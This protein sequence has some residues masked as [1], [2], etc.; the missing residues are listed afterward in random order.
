M[1][2]I[3]DANYGGKNKS[4][5]IFGLNEKEFDE[6]R[7]K[8]NNGKKSGKFG[9][10]KDK[11]DNNKSKPAHLFSKKAFGKKISEFFEKK[12]NVTIYGS[13]LEIETKSSNF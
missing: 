2:C 3:I 7:K 9:N 12:D 6:L 4:I 8:I 5:V 1:P 10:Y 13:L 11:S